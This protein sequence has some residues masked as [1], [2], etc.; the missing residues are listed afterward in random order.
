MSPSAETLHRR[1]QSPSANL[2]LEAARYLADHAGP[3]DEQPLREA[4]ARERIQWIRSALRRAIA[5]V[6]PET[7]SEPFEQSIDRDDFPA[8]FAAQVHAEAL[9][10]TASQLMHE[11][12]PMLGSLRV[13][14]MEEISEFDESNTR[15]ALD[16]LDDFLAALARLRKAASAPKSEE[17]SL[18]ATIQRCMQDTP[19]PEGVRVLGSGPQPCIVEGDSSLISLGF[20]NG[21]RN[22]IEATVA[23]GDDLA[24]RPIVVTWQTTNVECWISIVDVGIGFKGNLERAFQI[25]TTTKTGHLGMGLAIAEQAVASMGGRVMLVPNERGVRFEM[26]WPKKSE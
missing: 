10:T 16:R 19:T 23:A 8:G 21:L 15:R 24:E 26:R 14:A 6:S 5:R 9:E 17:F 7:T 22:A 11:I 4:L 3:H 18:D 2:R 1:L 25:G 13:A 12:E 20:C